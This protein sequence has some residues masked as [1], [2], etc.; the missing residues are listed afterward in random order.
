MSSAYAQDS[1]QDRLIKDI[2]QRLNVD[3]NV[4]PDSTKLWTFALKITIETVGDST[5]VTAFDT[6][7]KMGQSIESSF[8]ALKK[9]NYKCIMGTEKQ[10]IL[11]IPFCIVI[12]N[13]GNQ[14]RTL[15]MTTIGPDIERLFS[16]LDDKRKVIYRNPYIIHADKKVYD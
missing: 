8:A 7:H 2:D 16:G 3:L 1:C 13:S 9:L 10:K 11:V 14:K 5:R 6:N 15:S 4:F 12:Y